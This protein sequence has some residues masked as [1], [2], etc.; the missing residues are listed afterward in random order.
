M[1]LLNKLFGK[2]STS[3]TKAAAPPPRDSLSECD[4][5]GTRYETE[6]KVNSFWTPYILGRP[7]FPFI[8]Y[9]MREKTD[10]MSAMLSLQPFKIASDSGKL[11]ST[12]VLQFGVYPHVVNGKTVSWGFFLAGD[13]ITLT[14]YDAAIAS[15]KKYNGTDPR[16]SD[17]PKGTA[18]ASGSSSK[19]VLASV[20]FDWEEKV[21][22]LKQMKARGIEI[23]GAGAL[24][25]QV[26]TKRHHK[27][28]NKDTAL[29][30]LKANSVDRP[31]YYLIVHTPEGVFGRDKD[32]IFEQ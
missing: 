22:M 23:A 19:P 9:D 26:A 28:P 12:E 14:L 5:V 2:T 3:S 27:A 8:F 6:E 25:A 18:A 21:D 11:I 1:G 20:T 17:P 16:V 10:A 32:G 24:P 4:N 7:K 30:F 15:C 31:Y 13:R 29:A